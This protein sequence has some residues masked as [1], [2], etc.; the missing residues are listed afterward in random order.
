MAG[1]SGISDRPTARSWRGREISAEE[2]LRG[3]DRIDLGGTVLTVVIEPEPEAAP[4]P[5]AEASVRTGGSPAPGESGFPALSL[6]LVCDFGSGQGV[7]ELDRGAD[8]VRIVLEDGRWKLAR[9]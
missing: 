8:P 9:T 5:E 2:E 4:E 7:L 3:G 1:R 6:R